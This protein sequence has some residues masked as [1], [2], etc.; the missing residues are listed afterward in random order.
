MYKDL[1]L[2]DLK[3]FLKEIIISHEVLDPYEFAE[4]DI[5]AVKNGDRIFNLQVTFN[6][7]L[8]DGF[9]DSFDLLQNKLFEEIDFNKENED[10]QVFENYLFD[11]KRGG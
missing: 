7:Y 10:K 4:S 2:I 1:N 11:I 3:L 6:D 9:F 8:I 5:S